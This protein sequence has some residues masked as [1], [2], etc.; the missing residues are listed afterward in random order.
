MLDVLLNLEPRQESNDV[1]LVGEND[2]VEELFFVS[3]GSFAVGFE[4]NR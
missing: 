2:S 1:I 3:N 4:L